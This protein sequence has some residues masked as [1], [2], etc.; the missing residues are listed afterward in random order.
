[1]FS[2]QQLILSVGHL[3]TPSLFLAF[4]SSNIPGNRR[5]RIG[6]W[7][8]HVGGDQ[9]QAQ[10]LEQRQRWQLLRPKLLL[11]QIRGTALIGVDRG[12][13][14]A[15]RAVGIAEAPACEVITD[16]IILRA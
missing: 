12:H 13:S 4:P 8:A 10:A 11:A 14:L 5:E 7:A 1:M 9:R 16:P 6:L 3:V 2:M 15:N